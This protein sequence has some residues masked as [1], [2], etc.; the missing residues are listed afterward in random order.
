MSVCVHLIAYMQLGCNVLAQSE[1]IPV[2]CFFI[3]SVP[4]KLMPNDFCCLTTGSHLPVST[5]AYRTLEA[6]LVSLLSLQHI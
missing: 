5:V 1:L 3:T 2:E 4:I 6:I